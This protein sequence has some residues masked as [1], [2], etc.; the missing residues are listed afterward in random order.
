[1][2]IT[3]ELGK[4]QSSEQTAMDSVMPL[5]YQELKKL[6]RSFLRRES[7]LVRFQQTTLVHETYLKLASGRHPSYQNR[8]HFFGVVRRAMRQVLVDAARAAS[9]SKR[10]KMLEIAVAETPEPQQQSERAILVL[11]DLLYQLE[12]ESPL[13]AQLIEMH[14]FFGMTADE[15]AAAMSLPV[16]VV[17]GQLRF[18]MAWLRKE[19]GA[20][21]DG[22][23]ARTGSEHDHSSE[24]TT[25]QNSF[26]LTHE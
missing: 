7:G 13:K 9:A 10:G 4:F 3:E 11:N 19:M 16:H 18:A 21:R 26:E 6:A 5:V 2:Q 15:S 24:V 23:K 25:L 8:G 12:K 20:R 14:Y 1:M 17:R 22:S